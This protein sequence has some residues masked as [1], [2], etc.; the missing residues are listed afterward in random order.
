MNIHEWLPVV[1][2]IGIAWSLS[3]NIELAF[4]GISILAISLTS[5]FLYFGGLNE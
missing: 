2:G 3:R 5:L 1:A 4:L